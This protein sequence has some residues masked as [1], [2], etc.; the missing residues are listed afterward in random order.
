MEVC[1]AHQTEDMLILGLIAFGALFSAKSVYGWGL[2]LFALDKWKAI[3]YCVLIEGVMVISPIEW[4]RLLAMIFLVGINV[5]A[6]GANLME[7]E[8]SPSTKTEPATTTQITVVPSGPANSASYI[9]GQ[10]SAGRTK[11]EVADEL[12]ITVRH[13]NRVIN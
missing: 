13:L 12:G 2:S 10:L 1:L 6:T 11:R 7:L 3:G 5:I 9:L 8:P 4:L